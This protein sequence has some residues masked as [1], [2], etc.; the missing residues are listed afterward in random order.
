MIQQTRELRGIPIWLLSAY[1]VEI[2]GA[3]LDSGVIAGQGW[4]IQLQQ[5]ADFQVGS[6]R[7]GQVRLDLEAEPAVY[8]ALNEALDK[9]LLRAGG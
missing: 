9:K 8:P 4:K 1:L 5:L 7:V 2:G 6:I 3:E